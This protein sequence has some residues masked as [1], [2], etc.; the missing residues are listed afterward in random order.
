MADLNDF[1]YVDNVTN[2]L[3]IQINKLLATA[4][5][6]EYKNVE[7]LAATRTLTDADTPIQRFDCNGAARDVKMPTGAAVENHLFWI[8]NSSAGAFSITVKSNDGATTL[9]TIA[10]GVGSLFIPN[11]AGAYLAGG[12]GDLD[13]LTL[14]GADMVAA[15]TTDIG[16]ATGY[17]LTITGNTPITSFGTAPA[18]RF[19]MLKFA[20][21][22]LLTYNA[23]SLKLPG[24]ANYQVVAGDTFMFVS[25]GSGNWK[26]VGYALIS[27]AAIV[28]GGANMSQIFAVS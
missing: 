11:G 15:A 12:G 22:P 10:Q 6:S 25:E 24:A 26:C 17:E 3:A 28:G 5:R 13:S 1:N 9:G 14:Q 18:G 8:V 16:A 4:L 20:G 2:V 7:V 21:T 23:T 27:G 19:R